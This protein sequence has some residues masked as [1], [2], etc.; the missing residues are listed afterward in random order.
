MAKRTGEPEEAFG[1]ALSGL[2]FPPKAA[3]PLPQEQEFLPVQEYE[4]G[5]QLQDA[6]PDPVVLLVGWSEL[7]EEVG[8]LASACGFAVQAAAANA[9]EADSFAWLDTVYLVP[10]YLDIASICGIDRESFICVFVESPA[11]CEDILAQC[12]ATDAKYLGVDGSRESC[13]EILDAL[14]A[15]GAPDAELAAIACPMG[16]NLGAETVSQKSVAIVAELLGAWTGALKSLRP[17][18]QGLH[19]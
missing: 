2:D 4:S 9:Q 18:L 5:L 13:R 7:S 8:R 3:L 1:P 16:L 10:D 19:R 12:M 14:K 11:I 6:V 15:L 17:G